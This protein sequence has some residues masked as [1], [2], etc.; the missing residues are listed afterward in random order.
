MG[1]KWGEE[2]KGIEGVGRKR[3]K[4]RKGK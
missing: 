4:N 3:G 1:R 2:N